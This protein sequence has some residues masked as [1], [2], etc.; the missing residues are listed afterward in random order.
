MHAELGELRPTTVQLRESEH[1]ALAA[2]AR[3]RGNSKAGVVRRLIQE[4]ARR[5]HLW[6]Q[7]GDGDE[8]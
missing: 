5:L 4:E 1:A 3:V 8:S 2:I 6:A 7:D